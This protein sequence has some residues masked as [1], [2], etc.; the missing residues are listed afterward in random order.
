VF[1]CVSQL[2]SYELIVAAIDGGVPSLTSSTFVKI[3]LLDVNDSPPQFSNTN[4]TAT[5]QVFEKKMT[6]CH[7]GI[8]CSEIATEILLAM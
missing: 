8:I 4:F 7:S 1:L 6:F 5:I 2:P 3:Q